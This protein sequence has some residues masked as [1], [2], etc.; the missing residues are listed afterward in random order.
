MMI[1]STYSALSESREAGSFWERGSEMLLQRG[2][3][4]DYD[5]DWMVVDFTMI[6]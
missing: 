6:N 5:F 3:V 2:E 4:I 1:G